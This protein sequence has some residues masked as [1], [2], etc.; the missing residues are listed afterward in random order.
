MLVFLNW[1]KK[2][3]DRPSIPEF[4]KAS[5]ILPVYN[6]ESVIKEKVE[7]LLNQDYPSEKLEIIIISDASRDKTEKIVQEYNNQSIKLLKME[8]RSG[9]SACINAGVKEA[10]GKILVFTDANTIFEKDAVKNMV[11]NFAEFEVAGVC[12]FL[13]IYPSGKTKIESKYWKYE[14]KLKEL[15]GNL[16]SVCGANGGIYA[17]E[18]TY[19]KYLPEHKNVLDDFINSVQPIRY[20]KRVVFEKEARAREESAQNLIG[21]FQRKT[22]IGNANYNTIREVAFLFNIFKLG[23]ISLFFMLHKFL[24]WLSPILLL[25]LYFSILFVAPEKM[26]YGWISAAQ[27]LFYILGFIGWL[28][29][30]KEKSPPILTPISYFCI[31]NLALLQGFL[32]WMFKKSKPVWE[33]IRKKKNETQEE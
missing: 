22:R 31:M 11:R 29:L 9:K 1:G 24:R 16:A 30:R 10:E 7:N 18:K 21:E 27:G 28:F 15:E 32:N 3:K 23:R 6:E 4:P 14:R 20:K 26:F 2:E 17:I 5:V 33:P 12:G 19:F 13:E 8:K 25:I